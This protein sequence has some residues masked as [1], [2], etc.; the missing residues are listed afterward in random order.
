[1]KSH[2]A[3]YGIDPQLFEKKDIQIHVPEGAVPKDGPSAGITL[4]TAVISALTK[5]PV[6]ADLAMTGEVTLTGNVL[7]IGGLK[8]KSMAAFR[9]GI[10]RI[11][12][13]KRNMRDM[14]EIPQSVNS[15]VSF[16]PVETVEQVL[17]E[18]VV[19]DAV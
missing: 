12:I 9:S 17:K 7:P 6:Y 18:A 4:T 2:A 3:D 10:L 13:P 11:I 15:A 16:V 1:M 8:E 19:Q 5:K 14:D